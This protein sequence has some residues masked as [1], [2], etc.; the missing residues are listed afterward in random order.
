MTLTD[1][2][3]RNRKVLQVLRE[4]RVASRSEIAGR[5]NG[6]IK[7]NQISSVLSRLDAFGYVE[8][9][10][11]R[12]GACWTL[13]KSGWAL[14]GETPPLKAQIENDPHSVTQEEK[15]IVE[16]PSDYDL[17][18]QIIDPILSSME[19]DV[20]L[21]AVLLRLRLP[22]IPAQATRIYRRLIAELP[23]PV[24]QALEPITNMVETANQ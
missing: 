14:F 6:G 4:L 22:Q 18:S 23:E 1:L 15:P 20:A 2:S 17:P 7:P 5:I 9:P 13:S 19:V 16:T 21:D 8:K 3:E 12:N 10:E 11:D 24:R